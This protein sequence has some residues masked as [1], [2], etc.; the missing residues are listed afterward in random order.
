MAKTIAIVFGVIFLVAGVWGLVSA[1]AVGFIAAD[2]LSSVVHIV[3]GL[4]LLVASVKSSAGAALRAVGII[5]IIFAILGLVQGDWVLFGAFATDSVTNWFY[6]IVGIVVAA[7]GFA[8]KS[9]VAAP[10]PQM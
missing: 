2:T 7:L 8:S 4:V 10:A 6:L 5:Y 1:P 3:V 9:D